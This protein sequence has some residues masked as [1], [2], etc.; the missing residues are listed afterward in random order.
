SVI[1]GRFAEA[2]VGAVDGAGR[3]QGELHSVAGEDRELE[4]AALV[5]DLAE[6]GLGGREE[7]RLGGDVDGFGDVADAE[8]HVDLDGVVDADLDVLADEL[9]EAGEL[10]GDG[11]DAGN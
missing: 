8:G 1:E 3:E 11:V 6:G 4:D 10:G 7:R 5:D 2:H 9:L